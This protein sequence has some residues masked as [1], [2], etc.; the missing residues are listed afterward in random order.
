MWIEKIIGIDKPNQHADTSAKRFNNSLKMAATC[1]F[2]ASTRLKHLGV[3]TSHATTILSLFLI[4][5]PLLQIAGVRFRLSDELLSSIQIFLAVCILVYSVIN[6]QAKYSLRAE[7]L[8][9]CG[10]KIKK[11]Q[12]KLDYEIC[13]GVDIDLV[14]YMDKYVEIEVDS[15]NHARSD[16]Y[17]ARLRSPDL[18]KITGVKRLLL[19]V[20]A[21][22]REFF[23]YMG[24]V[25]MYAL[26][27]INLK[28]QASISENCL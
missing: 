20:N 15:E 5:I 10:N 23:S 11:L 7:K 4:L 28:M 8:N 18:Y 17:F 16:Y 12:R 26:Y 14:D 21:I 22:K 3:M 13:L 6:A 19:W 25:L 27:P 1:R 2:I 9:L 24:M